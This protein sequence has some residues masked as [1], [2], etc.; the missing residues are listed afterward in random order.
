MCAPSRPRETH[1]RSCRTNYRPITPAGT[2]RLSTREI[3]HRPGHVA[4][5]RHQGQLSAKKK[6]GA[7]FIDLTAAW[8]CMASRAHLQAVA[9]ATWQ[10][11]GPY[12]HGDGWQSQ[13]HPCHQKRRSRLRRFK[14]GVPQGSVLATLSSTSYV[15][16]LPNTISR[17]YDDD[18]P[19]MTTYQKPESTLTTY[20]LWRPTK[21]QKVRWR[22]T[23]Y[24]CW[25]RLP[26]G[27]WQAMEGVA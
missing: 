25:W 20:Q 23:N 9:I 17:K 24:A 1:L 6:A 22:P 7:V 8:H 4:D 19:I 5:T 18:L 26:D 12:D 3:D 10:T 13:L 14:N 21:N 16:D 27:D 11:H 2:S 15:S